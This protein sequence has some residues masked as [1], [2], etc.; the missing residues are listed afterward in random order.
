M[1]QIRTGRGR[2]QRYARRAGERAAADAV[3]PARHQSAYGRS[4]D[5]RTDEALSR[6]PLRFARPRQKRRAGWTL[7]DR[8]ARTRCARHHGCARA[9]SGALDRTLER[10]HDR[11]V[12]SDARAGAYRA[13][14]ARQ[15]RLAYAAAGLMEPAHSHRDGQ[16]HG[17]ADAG[18]HRALVHAGIPQTR[19]RNC[20]EDRAHAAHDAGAWLRSVVQR[21]LRHGS[22]RVDPCG[23]QS[24]ACRRRLNATPRRRRKWADISPTRFPAPAS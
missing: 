2:V 16:R 11:P 1:P 14:R 5:T 21:D 19:A 6:H 9:R 7:F 15:D 3:E 12:A 22:A 18:R 17:G 24:G 23:D 10:R 20:A 13:R 4:A 8:G